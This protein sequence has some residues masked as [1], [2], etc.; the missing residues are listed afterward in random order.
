MARTSHGRN[1]QCGTTASCCETSA[2]RWRKKTRVCGGRQEGT[3][4]KRRMKTLAL[5]LPKG[6]VRRYRSGAPM[7]RG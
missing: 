3:E 6:R 7:K 4:W 2:M 1:E 5:R